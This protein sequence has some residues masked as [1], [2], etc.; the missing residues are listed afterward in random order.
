MG[1]H[2]LRAERRS[3]VGLRGLAPCSR[4][5]CCNNRGGRVRRQLVMDLAGLL[6]S[7]LLY[8]DVVMS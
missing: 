2:K 6:D 1:K 8:V 4:G 5:P 3:R 7:F